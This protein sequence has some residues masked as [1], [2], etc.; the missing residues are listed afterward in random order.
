ML[1]TTTPN[2]ESVRPELVE[3]HFERRSWFDK[4]TTNGICFTLTGMANRHPAL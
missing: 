2:N 3:G 1:L 4:L